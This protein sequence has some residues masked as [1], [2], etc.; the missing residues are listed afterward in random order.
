MHVNLRFIGCF[1]LCLMVCV[2]VHPQNHQIIDSLLEV[3]ETPISKK[4]RVDTYVK[5]SEAYSGQNCLNAE[6]YANKAIQLAEETDYPKG[7]IGAYNCIAW[8]KVVEGHYS[9][10]SLLFNQVSEDSKR[11]N[12]RL[13]EALGMFGI[14][15]VQ[16]QQSNYEEALT[17]FSNCLRISQ[18]IGYQKGIAASYANFG[19]IYFYQGE[20]E[21]AFILKIYLSY[22]IVFLRANSPIS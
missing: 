3:L 14:G 6:D 17:Y 5:I 4:E 12:Y 13:G 7:R 21:K 11:I 8:C 18:E 20:Y 10:A 2:K 1:I 16:L 22:S 9:E 15:L 19:G